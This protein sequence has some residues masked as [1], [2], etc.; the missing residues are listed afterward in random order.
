MK[1]NAFEVEID[2]VVPG[3][4]RDT[5][6]I[7]SLGAYIPDALYVAAGEK[8]GCSEGRA[9]ACCP[10]SSGFVNERGVWKHTLAF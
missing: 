10:T 7:Y 8:L 2:Q 1:L 4:G 9:R 6:S 3:A 5:L